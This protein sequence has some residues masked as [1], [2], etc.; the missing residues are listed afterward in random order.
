MP[1]PVLQVGATVLCP[2]G[3]QVSAVT[4]NSRVLL[5]GSPAVTVGDTY[6]VAGCVFNVSGKPQPCVT[7][8]WMVVATRV[9]VGGQPVVIQGGSGLCY[10]AEQAPQGPASVV[11]T[12][13]KV[14]AT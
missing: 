13:P 4:S 2:H 7:A 3:G 1:G 6:P 10:S 8:K 12:Q 14:V 5:G 11:S 9:M